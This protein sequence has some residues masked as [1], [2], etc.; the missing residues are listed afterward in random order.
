[1]PWDSTA[2]N[3]GFTCGEPWLPL[4]A[5]NIARAVSAQQG[6]PASPLAHTRAMLALRRAHLAL[7]LGS[8][9]ALG[10]HGDVL[11]FT[12]RAGTEAI[13]CAF[14]IGGG[15]HAHRAPPGDVLL[16]LNGADTG[17]MPPWGVLF[18]R[19]P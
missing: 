3:A 13:H 9:E 19:E 15:R 10:V 16:T 8:V 1:M 11:S 4:S 12:R 17:H 7:R 14:N 2:P 18:V 6:D 5:G